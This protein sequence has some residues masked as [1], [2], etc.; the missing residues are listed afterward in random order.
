V[1]TKKFTVNLLSGLQQLSIFPVAS[2][3]TLPSAMMESIKLF[4]IIIVV[5][6]VTAILSTTFTVVHGITIDQLEQQQQQQQEVQTTT[7][8]RNKPFETIVELRQAVDEYL[9]VRHGVA[10]ANAGNIG[11]TGNSAADLM[12]ILDQHPLTNKY[13]LIEDWDISRIDNFGNLFS[14][15]R[16]PLTSIY[17]DEYVDLSTWDTSRVTNTQDMFLGCTNMDMDFSMWNMSRVSKFNGM[18]EACTN[19]QGRGLKTWDVSN[20]Q[21]FQSMFSSSTSLSSTQFDISQWKPR[22]AQNLNNMFRDSNFGSNLCGWYQYL[23]ITATTTDMF[24]RSQCPVQSDPNLLTSVQYNSEIQGGVGGGAVSF[25]TP[26]D[27]SDS[28][29]IPI[30]TTPDQKPPSNQDGSTSSITRPNVLFI[31]TDQQRFDS[32]RW[33]QDRLPW[34]N[35][36]NNVNNATQF[37]ID[38]PNLDAL[39]KSGAY[40][41]NAYTQCAV[42]APARTTLRTGCTIE[43]HGVQ[44]NDLY[45][46]YDR[47]DLFKDRVNNVVSIDQLL[48]EELGY[49]S[50]V[51]AHSARLF[52]AAGLYFVVDLFHCSEPLSDFLLNH[53]H[54]KQ[55]STTANGTYLTLLDNLVMGLADV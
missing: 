5:I 26:C 44:E 24:L 16:N 1:H 20:G 36:L 29:H 19:F 2:C 54:L 30:S 52:L 10:T 41:D 31:M 18:F 43:R 25:C 53:F 42:C 40:F 11:G 9:L 7:A 50:E 13:G 45:K 47:G 15:Q 4:T 17:V 12:V 55:H 48:V 32:I 39:L 14:F 23:P 22:K 49:V 27:H 3:R 46:W 38:T 35:D 37:K 21:L 34:Y 6:T 28:Q 8:I 33:V 51:R